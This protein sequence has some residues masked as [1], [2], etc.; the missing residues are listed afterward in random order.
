MDTGSVPVVE[1]SYL[2]L[3]GD[4]EK[5]R[6]IYPGVLKNELPICKQ[7][8][9]STLAKEAAEVWQGIKLSDRD[10]KVSN[11]LSCGTVTL[12]GPNFDSK[13][14]RTYASMWQGRLLWRPIDKTGTWKHQ[15]S[16]ST[17]FQILPKAG[18]FAHLAM[19]ASGSDKDIIWGLQELLCWKVKVSIV[20]SGR[21]LAIA[22]AHM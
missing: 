8:C 3:L 6:H 16:H 1:H 5:L 15:K 7:I 14:L 12:W 13:L 11:R 2:P 20:N 10:W 9:K 21:R 18:W 22:Q 4:R 17:I 19:I